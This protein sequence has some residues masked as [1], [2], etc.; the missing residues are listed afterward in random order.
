MIF[1]IGMPIIEDLMNWLDSD[2]NDRDSVTRI[3]KRPKNVEV[4]ICTCVC[5]G[6]LSYFDSNKY[7]QYMGY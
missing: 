4:I 1:R 6:D 3:I 5:A 7:S 2:E